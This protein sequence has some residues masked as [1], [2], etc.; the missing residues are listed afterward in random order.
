MQLTD[1][2]KEVL[3]RYLTKDDWVKAL[4][5]RDY[6]ELLKLTATYHINLVAQMLEEL[7][8]PIPRD[9]IRKL[10]AGFTGVHFEP[11]Y[12]NIEYADILVNDTRKRFKVKIPKAKLEKNI[13][14]L[15]RRNVI[16]YYSFAY[17]D[18]LDYV[19][20]KYLDDI[21]TVVSYVH[22]TI[23]GDLE[24]HFDLIDSNGITHATLQDEHPAAPFFI[25]VNG[26]GYAT[27]LD[28]IVKYAEKLFKDCLK[29]LLED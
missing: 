13:D 9:E 3:N 25:G 17:E 23:G 15:V 21:C 2:Q 14:K 8:S 11:E 1:K 20:N 16:A 6:S 19:E 4:D 12:D 27:N 10:F 29:V 5:S 26:I 22:V 7:E 24:F 28:E 18:S